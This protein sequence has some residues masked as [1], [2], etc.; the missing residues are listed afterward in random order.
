[1]A[2]VVAKLYLVSFSED[3]HLIICSILFFFFI[4]YKKMCPLYLSINL[5]DLRCL[6][7]FCSI[8]RMWNSKILNSTQPNGR[9]HVQTMAWTVA[10]ASSSTTYG[11]VCSTVWWG[12][13]CSSVGPH[14]SS[15]LQKV[16]FICM[17]HFSLLKAKT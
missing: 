1:M 16:M 10:L 11:T 17:S 12:S 4:F 3:S 9:K 13:N 6:I 2:F 7:I 8:F 5:S 15:L 14:S